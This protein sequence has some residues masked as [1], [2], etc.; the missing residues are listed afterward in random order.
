MGFF[1]KILAGIVYH[2]RNAH[3]LKTDGNIC[4]TNSRN[5]TK[6]HLE[7]PEQLVRSQWWTLLHSHCT[8]LKALDVG[9]IRPFD[10]VAADP[11]PQSWCIWHQPRLTVEAT[12]WLI[13][14]VLSL[15]DYFYYL[16]LNLAQPS[17]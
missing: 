17:F 9:R 11:S 5:S 2:Y 13:N 6:Y 14:Y 10:R 12:H 15:R 8:L 3:I 7:L 16:N 4:L 1:R